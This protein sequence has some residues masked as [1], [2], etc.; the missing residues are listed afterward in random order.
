VRLDKRAIAITVEPTE[1]TEAEPE[2]EAAALDE[3]PSEPART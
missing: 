2:E 3:E 1:E